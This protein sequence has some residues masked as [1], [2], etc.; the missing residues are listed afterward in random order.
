MMARDDAPDIAHTFDDPGNARMASN[1]TSEPFAASSAVAQTVWP[2]NNVAH[3][4]AFAGLWDRTRAGE[5][6]SVERT[7]L[8]TTAPNALLAPIAPP[9]AR[10]PGAPRVRGMASAGH[11]R[12]GTAA[13][14]ARP[15][16]RGHD[17]AVPGVTASELAQQRYPGRHRADRVLIDKA[18]GTSQCD[19]R[20]R[21]RPDRG[22]VR[23]RIG[24]GAARRRR[25]RDRVVAQLTPD[26]LTT[27]FAPSWSSDRVAKRRSRTFTHE[28]VG[29]P[30][31][32]PV[33]RASRRPV[34][35]CL[36]ERTHRFA[37]V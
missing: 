1:Q 5:A 30:N 28:A 25:V 22:V 11:G 16:R 26:L 23:D 13:G 31:Q 14:A 4:F 15:V 20:S 32:H 7:V 29:A 33:A 17:A 18:E 34:R 8:I 21:L 3:P 10:D 36:S 9:H 35:I 24:R 19:E 2:C 6:P 27:F 37:F 12:C